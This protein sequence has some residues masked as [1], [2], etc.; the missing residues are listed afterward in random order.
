VLKKDSPSCGMTRVKL[1]GEKGRAARREASGLFAAALHAAW[2]S[3]P[4]EEEGRLHDPALRE[5]FLERVFA[6]RRLQDLFRGRWTAARL[7]AFHAAHELQLMAHSPSACAELGRLVAAQSRIPRAALRRRY[8]ED[9]MGAL[10][11]VATRGRNASVLRR[12][13]GQLKGCLDAPARA[14]LA[15]LIGDYRRGLVPLAAPIAR[16]H[17]HARANAVETLEVQTFLEPD[18]RER[19]LRN[20]I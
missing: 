4:L 11:K 8:S 20:E 10:A 19:M 2:P 17:H 12:A 6:Y 9:F 15:G 3:L 7:V 16:L 1:Y 13:A 14:E 18:P 5:H